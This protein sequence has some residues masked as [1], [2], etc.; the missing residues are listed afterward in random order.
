MFNCGSFS[1]GAGRACC[2]NYNLV[3]THKYQHTRL[4]VVWNF[5]KLKSSKSDGLSFGGLPTS[6]DYI[7]TSK[8][9]DVVDAAFLHQK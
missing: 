7:M 5:A 1:V 8:D 4:Q 9:E 2:R 6:M 3:H